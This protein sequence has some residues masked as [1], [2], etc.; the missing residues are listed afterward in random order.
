VTDSQAFLK[1]AA[2]TP[3]NVAMTSFS[4]LFARLK[5]DLSLYAHGAAAIDR[6]K[7]RDRILIAESCA[8]H[9]IGED[10]GTVKIPRWLNQLTG[11]GLE[12]DFC[13]GHDFPESLETYRLIIQCGGC[14][15]NRA[16]VLGRVS[17]A[18]AKA[19]PITNYGLAIAHSLGICP[20]ALKP[21]PAA[22]QAY[23]DALTL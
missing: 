2:D 11:G 5:G 10:I 19:V 9:P 7:P 23:Q 17:L 15:F 8:H 21:F 4:V 22:L 13:R 20:R 18:Q 12:F 3:P 1:V 16:A 6:L 14:R